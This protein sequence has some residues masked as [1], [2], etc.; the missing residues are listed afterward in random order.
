MKM[1]YVWLASTSNGPRA[2]IPI[3][4]FYQRL[5]HWGGIIL[6]VCTLGLPDVY[7]VHSTFLVGRR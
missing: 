3:F 7:G 5:I 4:I 1:L 6:R 2:T